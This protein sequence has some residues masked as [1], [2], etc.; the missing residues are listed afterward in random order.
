MENR[1]QLISSL[2]EHIQKIKRNRK[3]INE[4]KIELGKYHILAGEIQEW[5]NDP[6]EKLPKLD[7]RELYL[8]T[9]QIFVKTGEPSINPDKYFTDVE[10]KE[11]RIYDASI[12]RR[13]L[14]FPVTFENASIVGSG[15]WSV[16]IDIKM[17]DM[18]LENQLLH[19]DPELQ[20]EM[21]VKVDRSGKIRYEPTLVKKNVDE[22]AEH[23]LNGTLVPT[24]WVWNAAL[25]SSDEGE[26]IVFDPQY[27]TITITKG[28]KMAVVDGFHR[29]KGA[30]KALRTNPDLEFNFVLIITNYTKS[31]AQKYQAQLAEATPISKNRQVQLKSERYSDGI[32]KRLMQESDLKERISQNT[33]IKSIANQLVSYSVLADSIDAYFEISTKKDAVKVGDYL[34]KFFDELI[35]SFPEEFIFNT[36][37]TR[38]TSLINQN[39]MFVGYIVLASRMWKKDISVSYLSDIINNIDFNKDNPLWQ[40]IGVINER[41]NIDRDTNKLRKKIANYFKQIDIE[42]MVKS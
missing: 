26:E 12:F 7:I 8:F 31:Q 24:T 41:G 36:T 13:T 20:R 42:G 6:K 28:T 35:G 27:R 32:V 33:Q 22:I 9:E 18:M 11:A 23:I 3:V 34:I 17:A 40:D 10:R 30:Q 4:I 1:E 21:K 38:K 5:I 37:E 16:P 25:G 39:N 19:Y 2:E 15:A 29:L 14:D